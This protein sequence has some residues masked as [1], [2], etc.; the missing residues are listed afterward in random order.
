V[1]PNFEEPTLC[2]VKELKE[3]CFSNTRN[4]SFPWSLAAHSAA[5]KQTNKTKTHILL[6]R[7]KPEFKMEVNPGQH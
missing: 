5:L 3:I 1:W 2:P 7:K 4:E 6:V